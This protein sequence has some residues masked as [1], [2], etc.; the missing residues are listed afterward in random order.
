MSGM[1]LDISEDIVEVVLVETFIVLKVTLIHTLAEL[2]V[3]IGKH[4]FV[5]EISIC[6][7]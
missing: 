6:I 2:S 5:D 7:K 1:R 4:I 3:V